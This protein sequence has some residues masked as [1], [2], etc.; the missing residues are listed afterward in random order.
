ML[1]KTKNILRWIA[2]PFAAVASFSIFYLLFINALGF[3][4]FR[5]FNNFSLMAFILVIV[6]SVLGQFF[7]SRWIAPKRKILT[8]SIT[9]GII[10]IIIF[11]I[12]FAMRFLAY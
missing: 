5:L 6:L 2:L 3:I 8:A 10:C 1:Q 12:I 7:V 11:Y 4:S 9:T